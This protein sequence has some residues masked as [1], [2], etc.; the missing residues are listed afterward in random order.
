M[1]QKSADAFCIGLAYKNGHVTEWRVGSSS[2]NID[3][4]VVNSISQVGNLTISWA[5]LGCKKKISCEHQVLVWMTET[6]F[7][8]AKK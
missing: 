8:C 2:V 1:L 7:D 5:G 3:E 6:Y 4:L